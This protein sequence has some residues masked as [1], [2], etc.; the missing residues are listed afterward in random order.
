MRKTALWALA[1]SLAPLAY[2]NRISGP[3]VLKAGNDPRGIAVADL[4]GD[5]IAEVVLANFGDATLIGQTTTAATGSIQIF[6]NLAL[7]QTLAGGNS[8]RSLAIADL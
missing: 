5:G 3:A 6:K 2:A 1:M 8:P 4:D 7:S